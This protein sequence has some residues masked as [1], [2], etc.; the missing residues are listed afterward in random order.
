MQPVSDDKQIA[1][2]ST[3]TREYITDG[4]SQTASKI[5]N[6]VIAAAPATTKAISNAN[7]NLVKVLEDKSSTQLQI[8]KAKS[9][10]A[11]ASAQTILTILEATNGN[12][13]SFAL[14]MTDKSVLPDIEPGVATILTQQGS[15]SAQIKVVNDSTVVLTSKQENLSLAVSAVTSDGGLAPINSRGAVQVAEGMSLAVTGSGFKP[16]SKVALWM[17][18]SPRSFGFVL[19]DSSGSFAAEV[20]MPGD[21]VPG[22]HTVQINGQHANGSTRSLNLG[23]EMSLKQAPTKYTA[24]LVTRIQFD[25]QSVLLTP[26]TQRQ[27]SLIA[28]KIENKSGVV[29]KCA[30]YTQGGLVGSFY[31]LAQRRADAVC[32]RL[33]QLGVNAKFESVGVGPAKPATELARRVTITLVY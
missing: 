9:V 5:R 23:V 12:I 3:V 2:V 19:T 24:R 20:P 16:N 8:V 31:N 10:V 29:V 4:D 30:G 15:S 1:I 28:K 11:D 25:R 22:D 13:T 33:R 18:S 7:E 14:P 26:E 21:I 6:A 17:F 32:Q 27:L